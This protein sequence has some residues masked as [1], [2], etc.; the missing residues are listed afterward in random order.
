VLR[1]KPESPLADTS[2]AKSFQSWAA[3]E[4]A[5]WLA[6]ISEDPLLPSTLLPEDY[7]GREAWKARKKLLEDAGAQMRAFQF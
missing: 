4:R 5:A 3:E 2:V 1:R 6:A 7:K